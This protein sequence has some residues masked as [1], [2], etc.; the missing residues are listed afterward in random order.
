LFIRVCFPSAVVAGFSPVTSI[1]RLIDYL[2]TTCIGRCHRDISRTIWS[3]RQ[4]CST[5]A[6]TASRWLVLT[7]DLADS[8]RAVDGV[9]HFF[10]L[11][12][13]P[14]VLTL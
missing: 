14:L 7:A 6:R 12:V 8:A 4:S 9:K 10:L 3:Y 2:T 13:T 1:V 5:K 11:C